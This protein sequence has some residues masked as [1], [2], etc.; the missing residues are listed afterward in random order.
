MA[1]PAPAPSPL[2]TR[3]YID[4]YNLDYGCLKDTPYK[5]LDLLTLFEKHIPT[6]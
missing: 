2:R 5:W 3:V 6:M 4:G 1:A